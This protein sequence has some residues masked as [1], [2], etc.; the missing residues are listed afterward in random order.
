MFD[1]ETVRRNVPQVYLLRV[2]RRRSRL[3]LLVRRHLEAGGHREHGR[4]L[5]QRIDLGIVMAGTRES[6]ALRKSRLLAAG[7]CVGGCRTDW[8]FFACSEHVRD[9]VLIRGFMELNT[10]H[11]IQD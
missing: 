1:P 4:L 9:V 7:D 2:V 5:H 3:H 6:D 10:N 8:A 11:H